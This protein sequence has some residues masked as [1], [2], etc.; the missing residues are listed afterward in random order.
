[1]KKFLSAIVVVLLVLGAMSLVSCTKKSS[2]PTGP[3]GTS[4]TKVSFDFAT[5]NEGWF[6]PNPLYTANQAYT[7]LLYSSTVGHN[8]MGAISVSGSFNNSVSTTSI[9]GSY[10]LMEKGDVAYTLPANLTMTSSDIT[11]WIYVPAA[12]ATKTAGAYKAMIWV[13]NDGNDAAHA[14]GYANS[15]IPVLLSSGPTGT[16]GWV[17]VTANTS[18]F[19]TGDVSL[20][21]IAEIGCQIYIDTTIYTSADALNGV[22]VSFDDISYNY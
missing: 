17:S 8:A 14:Y 13:A 20:D 6:I 18:T 7:N 10:T 12:M 11:F 2:S 15:Q 21:N 16:A 1:M 4:K 22:T 9:N 19:T 3:T 5:T